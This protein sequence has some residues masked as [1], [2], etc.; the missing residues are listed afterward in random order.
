MSAPDTTYGC[1]SQPVE[2]VT[3]QPAVQSCLDCSA[4]ASLHLL[5]ARS[6]WPRSEKGL[7]HHSVCTRLGTLS[8]FHNQPK[9][10]HRTSDSHRSRLPYLFTVEKLD[11]AS[12]LCR[13]ATLVHPFEQQEGPPAVLGHFCLPARSK[14]PDCGPQL[15]PL[16]TGAL[17]LWATPALLAQTV[18][19]IL[20]WA[21]DRCCSWHQLEVRLMF[22]TPVQRRLCTGFEHFA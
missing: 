21:E 4:T 16:E 3:L 12:T 22:R 10:P 13:L 6:W 14:C 17:N 2:A 8:S 19:E 11:K 15:T 9:P 7:S 20:Q 5:A 18:R 1:L